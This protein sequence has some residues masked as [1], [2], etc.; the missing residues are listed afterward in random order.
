M[1]AATD[2]LELRP[3]GLYCPPAGVYIDPHRPVARAVVTHG[4]GD[5]CRPGSRALLAT[6]ETV[7]IAA[8]RYG[9]DAFA[10]AQALAPGETLQLGDATIRL[11]PAGHVLG[12]AQVVIEAH[13]RRAVVSGDYKRAPDPTC[14]P[15]EPVPCDLF[16]TEATF[17][18]P[19][20]RHPPVA[21]EIAR[22]LASVAAHPERCHAIGAYALGKA[23][24]LIA[25]LRAAGWDRPIFLHGALVGLC[26][27]YEREGVPLGPLEQVGSQGKALAGEIVL[28]PP[29]AL[30]DR[31]ARRLPDPVICAASGWM[32]VRQRA[33]QR[34]VELPLV[35]SDHADW[36]ELTATILETQAETVWV[37]HGAEE[38]LCHWCAGRGID[39]R[40]LALA[41][42]GEEEAM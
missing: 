10:R 31:W 9:R 25:E 23:Q 34:G 39:A 28:A 12:S 13:G 36:E 19:V 26:R 27:V 18:L 2:L 6:P 41:G 24:R 5:H 11:V 16:V 30:N 21:E 20:F 8:A 37:T 15:F 4:H 42:R 38:A 32:R 14:A 7:A 3:E 1:R 22:L 40:P 35:V 29:G 17:G 33:K